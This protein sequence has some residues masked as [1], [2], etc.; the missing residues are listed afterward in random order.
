M[1]IAHLLLAAGALMMAAQPVM[2]QQAEAAQAAAPAPDLYRPQDKLEQGLWMQMEE[3]ERG[4]KTSQLVIHDPALNGYV[5]GVLCRTVGDAAC[6][7]IRLYLMRT[8][9]FNAVTAPNG[10]MQ[11]WSGLL[12]RV[13]NEAQLSAVLGHEYA[14]FEKRHSLAL[15]HQAK[16]KSAAA[17]WLAFTGIGLIASFGLIGS[18]FKFSREQE[19]AADLAGLQKMAAAGYDTREAAVIW[20]Q[21]R[22][23]MDATAAARG[24]KSR[25]DKTGGMFA[26]HPP[27]AER[28]AYLRQAAMAQPGVPGET[29][30]ERYRAA[31][32]AWW[33]VFV[34]DQLKMNDFGA[35]AFLLDSIA[36]SGERSPWIDYARGEL[37][38]HR[39]AAGDLEKAEGLYSASIAAGAP[40]PELWRGR[41]LARL[42]LGRPDDGRADLKEYLARSPNAPDKDMITMISGGNA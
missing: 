35:S 25:K 3:S 10:A 16:S 42:K 34:D 26:T 40:L 13:Q 33:P 29:G 9:N 27:S 11:V 24:T 30:A 36:R 1:R 15:Y 21:L 7:N 23:E 20:E 37:Y 12:L 2:A 31:M 6:A 32:A 38:R 5:R 19:Q 17:A 4:L 14:H 18:L 22:D 41:G 8:P 39:A 28:V